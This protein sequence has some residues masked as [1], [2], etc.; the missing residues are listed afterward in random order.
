MAFPGK[1]FKYN[2]VRPLID[3]QNP[4]I[5]Y[6][7]RRDFLLSKVSDISLIWDCDDSLNILRKQK[8]GGFWKSK[9][10]NRQKAP[11]VNYDLF[12]TFKA[13]SRL[14]EM[15]EFD[16]TN[17]SIQRAADYLF[18]CQ[19][20]EGDFRGIIGEQYAPYYTGLIMSLLIR[21]GYAADERIE[22]GFSWLLS[23]RQNDG[24]WLIGSPGCF[25]DYSEEEKQR[26]TTHYVGT[27]RDFD[28]SRPFT[29]S[30]TGM[31][32]RAFAVHPEWSESEEACHAAAL[33][34]EQFFLKDNST[35]YQH[36]DNWVNFKYPFFWTDLISALDSLSLIGLSKDDPYIDKALKWLIDNQ[37]ETGLWDNSYSKI[38]SN[39][40]NEKTYQV[41]LWISLAICRIFNRFYN[42]EN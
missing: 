20:K 32:L 35:S 13:F 39:I 12:E 7:A 18:S 40:K 22:K 37:L 2:P 19:T 10:A 34:K 33:I 3:S 1:L 41:Q 14:I 5:S 17:Q 42:V 27:K 29:H 16:N 9:T 36:P 8:P 31:V 4:A 15:Y 25:G 23:M 26:I 24:G 11:A 21:A 38:H 30:G 28:F 6:F